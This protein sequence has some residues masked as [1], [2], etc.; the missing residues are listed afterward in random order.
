MVFYNIFAGLDSIVFVTTINLFVSSGLKWYTLNMNK[1]DFRIQSNTIM[2][3][4]L[5]LIGNMFFVICVIIAG[6]LGV[7]ATTITECVVVGS[8]MVPTYNKDPHTG[9]DIIYVNKCLRDFT[10]GDVVVVDIGE[11]YTPIIKRI[12]AMEGDTVDIVENGDTYWLEINGKLIH[13]DYLNID[14]SLDV[15]DQNG[16]SATLA[17]INEY[18]RETQTYLFNSDGKIVVPEGQVFVLGDNRHDSKD[19]TYYGTFYL[20]Q[21]TG[22]I[23][24]ERSGDVSDLEFYLDYIFDGKFFTTIMNC[25]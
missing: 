21:L 23:E 18:L 3:R 2:S 16:L 4:F 6:A 14:Y 19:S 7:F 17:N 20:E 22:K 12:V 8:S 11:D 5:N 25:F 24:L 13:E 10:Y 15:K 1:H 9:N